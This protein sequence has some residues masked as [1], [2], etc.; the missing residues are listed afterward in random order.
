MM[1]GSW[2]HP[3]CYQWAQKQKSL[4]N[5]VSH[6][7]CH[8]HYDDWVRVIFCTTLFPHH[9]SRSN[10]SKS[11]NMKVQSSDTN[12]TQSTWDLDTNQQS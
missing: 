8:T 6:K 9:A 7:I 4:D 11:V 5:K 3:S 1:F 2:P 12:T 10:G